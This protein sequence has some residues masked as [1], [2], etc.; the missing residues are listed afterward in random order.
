MIEKKTIFMCEILV[1]N[2]NVVDGINIQL[3]RKTINLICDLVS[4]Y[5]KKNI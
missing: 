5:T 2:T 3:E 4:N 1:F